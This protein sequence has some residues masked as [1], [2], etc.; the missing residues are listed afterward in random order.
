MP[1]RKYLGIGPEYIHAGDR[2]ILC[3]GFWG[4]ARHFKYMGEGIV[5][6]VDRLDLGPLRKPLGV[7]HI[8]TYVV[9]L[10]TYRQIY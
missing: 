2:K 7:D 1:E 5:R 8:S 10:L 4:A 6:T 9:G 3:S